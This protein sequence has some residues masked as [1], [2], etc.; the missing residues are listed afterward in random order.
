MSDVFDLPETHILRVAHRQSIY[1]R[2][3]IEKSRQCGCFYCLRMFGPEQIREWTDRAKP[4]AEQTAL[5]PYCGIDS[6]IGDCSGLDITE[7]F[8][9]DMK[10]HWFDAGRPTGKQDP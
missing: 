4:D 8:L 1:H 3:A 5:C 10:R 2:R 9:Q 7:A 6:V